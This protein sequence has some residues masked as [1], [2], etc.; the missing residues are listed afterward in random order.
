VRR[1]GLTPFVAEPGEPFNPERHQVAGSN[2]NP[3]ETAVVGETIGTGYTFQGK[4]L[5]HAIVRLRESNN[6]VTTSA[7]AK[8]SAAEELPL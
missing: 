2:S 8:I 3:P 4:F 1:I 6:P 7:P 5:R